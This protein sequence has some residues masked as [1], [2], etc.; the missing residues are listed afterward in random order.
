MKLFETTALFI[1]LLSHTFLDKN[2]KAFMIMTI[3]LMLCFS[4][5][6]YILNTE[7]GVEFRF[8][9]DESMINDSIYQSEL[10][11]SFVNAIV[12]SFKLGLGD[13]STVGFR[14]N[15]ENLTWI[16]FVL[17]TFLLQITFLNL[18]IAI[19]SNTFDHILFWLLRF[20]NRILSFIIASFIAIYWLTGLFFT[21]IYPDYEKYRNC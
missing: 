20:S 11:D 19:M 3:I 1:N 7:R 5:L 6:L 13:F 10:T 16:V 9:E 4:N 17:A 21:F 14:G 8:I 2:F 12:Y 15:N 18:I